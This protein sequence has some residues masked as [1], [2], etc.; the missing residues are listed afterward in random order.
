V[1]KT[2]EE[3]MEFTRTVSSPTALDD[4]EARALYDCCL[5]VPQDGSVVEIGSQ[6][7]RS[8]SLLTQMADGRFGTC[9]I[10]PYIDDPAYLPSWIA[11]MHRFGQPFIFL[12]MKSTEAAKTISCK[13]DL[14]F[15]DGDHEYASVRTDL[16]LFGVKVSQGGFL[17]MHDYQRE[18]LPGVTQ[19][20]DEYIDQR[21]EPIGVFSTLGVWRKK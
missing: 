12:H 16:L 4:D 8:S 17:V 18:S 5:E 14:L 20:A 15:I 11:T 1:S 6:L 2:F 9:H 21:W 3:V 19:A 7:G 13:I 10:D